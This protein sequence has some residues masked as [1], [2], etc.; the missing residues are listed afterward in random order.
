MRPMRQGDGLACS[1]MQNVARSMNRSEAHIVVREI[2]QLE[3]SRGFV[4]IRFGPIAQIGCQ[5]LE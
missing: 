2:G 5:P 4:P 1:R 3:S